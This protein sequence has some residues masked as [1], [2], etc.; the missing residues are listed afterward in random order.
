MNIF[1]IDIKQ[2]V[3][4]YTTITVVA[5][6]IEEAKG[7]AEAEI[8]DLDLTSSDDFSSEDIEIIEIREDIR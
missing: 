1:E 7:I 4:Y 3:Y 5:D 2:V 6:N 8:E